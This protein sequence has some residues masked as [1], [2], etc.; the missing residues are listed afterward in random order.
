ML[1]WHFPALTSNVMEYGNSL[2]HE[3]MLINSP[4]NRRTRRVVLV[5]PISICGD[6]EQGNRFSEMTTTIIVNATGALVSLATEVS[7]GQKL[8]MVNGITGEEISC[9]VANVTKRDQEKEKT[10]VGISFAEQKPRF[11]GISF[12][13]DDWDGTNRKRSQTSIRPN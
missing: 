11:W 8:Q 10:E 13:P 7:E 1:R 4:C 12:P 2:L 3:F 5:V 6:R 9:M